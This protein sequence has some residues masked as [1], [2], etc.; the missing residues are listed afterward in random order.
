MSTSEKIPILLVDDLADNLLVLEALLD[1]SVLA[2]VKAQSG[3]EA[4]RQVLHNDFALI[5]LDVQMP[6][7]DG[8]ET[9][10]L[11]RIN[12]KTRHIPIIFV[13]AGMKDLDLQFKGYESGA[14]DYL[15]KPIEP[16]V[17]KGK[18]KVFCEL[19]RQRKELEAYGQR[20]EMLVESRAV[21]LQTSQALLEEVGRIANVGGWEIDLATGK[22]IWTEQVH[23]IHEVESGYQPSVEK[24]IAFYVPQS[25]KAME[26]AVQQAINKGTA[27]DLELQIETARGRLRWVHAIGHAQ[28]ADGKTIKVSGI[29]QDITERKQIE[30]TLSFLAGNSGA[31]HGTSFFRPLARYLAAAL[32]ADYVCIDRLVEDSLSAE[33]LTVFF[34]GKFDSNLVYRLQDTPC[35]AVVGQQVCVFPTGVRDLF[36]HD[37]ALQELEAEG[38]MGV[39]LWNSSGSPIGLIAAISRQPIENVAL[40]ESILRLVA[41][42]AAGELER[43][44][45]AEVLRE[46]EARWTFALQGSGAGVWDWNLQTGK[47]YFSKRWKD[48]LGYS[49]DEIGNSSEEWV[50][51]VHANDLSG[52]K[53]ILQEHIEGKTSSATVEHRLLCKDGSWKWVMGRGVVVGRDSDGKPVRMVGTNTDINERKLAEVNVLLAASVFTHA[54][55]GIM[56]TAADA[57]IL[58]VNDTFTRITGYARDEVLG[59]NPRV[60]KSDR[61]TPEFYIQMW[62]DLIDK[63]HWYGELWNR[64]K[65]GEVYAQTL[66]ISAVRDAGGKTQNYVA[67][68]TD[69]T[70]MKN[71]QRQL[72][73]IAHYDTLTNLPNRVLFADRLQQAI[74]QSQR[75]EKTL[76]VAYIDLDGFKAVNDRYGHD[77]GDELLISVSHRMKTALREGDTLAR[78]GGDE[79]VT[80]LVALDNPRDCEPVL[81]R[82]L[83]AAADPVAV[84]EAVLQISASIGVTLYPQDG[85]E[86]DQL[87]RHADQAMYQAKQ[88]GKNRYHLFD[89]AQDAAMKC[90]NENFE[91][92]LTAVNRNEFVLYYQ[93][94]VNMN[95]GE[96]IGA[97]ALIRWQHP[98]H[99]LLLPNA[100][101]PLIEDHAISVTLGEWVIDTALK[102][103]IQWQES[104]LDVPVSVNIGA[105]QLQQDGFAARLSQVLAAHPELR[106]NSLQLELLETSALED[107][108]KVGAAMHACHNIGVNFALDDFGTGYSSLIYLKHLPA[109]TL[110]IDQSFVRDMLDDSS[111]LAIVKG[112]IG[113]AKAFDRHVIAE[114]VE[115][116]AHGDLLMSL[117]C[118][119]AQ[120]Y[121]I[122]RPMAAAELPLWVAR[123]HEDWTWKAWKPANTKA[124]YVSV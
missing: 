116:I 103:I 94:K 111:D 6:K 112:V 99:G 61:Q 65:D 39:T 12:P 47:A 31:I 69:I 109:E 52:V 1:E 7:M 41:V 108:A 123:W 68:F 83:Q 114:G 118:E 3:N 98:D 30:D 92:I 70:A 23:R 66:T 121:A 26:S 63:G 29:F 5:L 59:Q 90:Q 97:E 56:I 91:R 81:A 15:I 37:A 74:V 9:A 48:I 80:V 35:G 101:L 85:A 32:N 93:P 46:S 89:V 44:L 77:I 87:M 122:A 22:L 13:T 124:N 11:L 27:F 84:G 120:G 100:F 62:Q 64:R 28:F 55:E 2:L 88:A 119:Q 16:A 72:E 34:D 67:L 18:V 36:P 107:V 4:L 43:E 75:Q 104:G 24:A 20:M 54:R 78:I 14:V 42:R 25:R 79:F 102:Q 115:T 51:R 117:G 96:V 60:F 21:K 82:L 110:K 73:H 33:T 8:F 40:A 113:L 19:Y 58:Q 76:A 71:H 45:S 49:E 17:L 38:Y 95:T 10:E 86:A 106:P 105:R 53:A 50:K 57:T